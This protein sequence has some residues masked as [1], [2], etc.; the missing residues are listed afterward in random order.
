MVNLSKHIKYIGVFKRIPYFIA[1][2]MFLVN[3]RVP[4]PVHWSS[5]VSNHKNIKRADFRP[6]PGFMPGQYIQAINGIEI[7][8]NVRLGPGV[9][10]ISASHDLNDY[11]KHANSGPIVIGDNCWLSADVVVLPGVVLQEHV[12]VGAGAVVTKSFGPNVLI[13]GNPAKVIKYLPSYVGDQ[14]KW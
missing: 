2:R 7:G 6:Y 8:K 12:V 11:S 4:W 1:Q 9:K 14:D 5:I 13:G 3:F 10:L